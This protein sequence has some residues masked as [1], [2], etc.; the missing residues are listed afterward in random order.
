MPCGQNI[1]TYC[2]NIEATLQQIQQDFKN[3]PHLQKKKK[4]KKTLK[5]E[6]I[7]AQHCYG[8]YH[9]IGHQLCFNIKK[10]RSVGNISVKGNTDLRQTE[11][12]VL[13]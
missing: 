12:Q 11:T 3:G 6:L 13:V 9:N 5:R 1:K 2:N 4:K 10:K 8:N 7:I